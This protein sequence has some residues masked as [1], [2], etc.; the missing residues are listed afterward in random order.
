M[1]CDTADLDT[2]WDVGAE[3][4]SSRSLLEGHRLFEL[5]F[6]MDELQIELASQRPI[7][8]AHV[9]GVKVSNL[10]CAFE[11]HTQSHTHRKKKEL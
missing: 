5:K 8:C 6:Q 11:P 9:L 10:F 4:G 7:V 1:C 2:R 3:A